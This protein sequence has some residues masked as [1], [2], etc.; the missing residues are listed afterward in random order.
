M[1]RETIKALNGYS[2][3]RE[4]DDDG[5]FYYLVYGPNG[6]P[7][8][9]CSTLRDAEMEFDRQTGSEPKPKFDDPS[10]P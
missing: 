1:T 8:K 4:L 9:S 2:I 6:K 5:Q 7:I 10:G 3:V